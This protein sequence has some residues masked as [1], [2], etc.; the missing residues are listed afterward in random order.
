MDDRDEGNDSRR[1]KDVEIGAD[2]VLTTLVGL[3]P[4]EIQLGLAD[5]VDCSTGQLLRIERPT[6][7]NDLAEDEDLAIE[8]LPDVDRM[9]HEVEG[10]ICDPQGVLQAL[11]EYGSQDSS[12]ESL[13]PNEE[14]EDYSEE[15]RADDFDLNLTGLYHEEEVPVSSCIKHTGDLRVRQSSILV[16]RLVTLLIGTT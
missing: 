2:Q 5:V 9:I 8:F 7:V 11:E 13:G 3:N 10:G 12:D 16:N 14:A 6:D 4:N 1:Q 15:E